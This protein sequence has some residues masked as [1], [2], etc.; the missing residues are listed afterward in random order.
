[1]AMGILDWIGKSWNSWWTGWLVLVIIG[2]LFFGVNSNIEFKKKYFRAWIILGGIAF[3]IFALGIGFPV[4]LVLFLVL[5]MAAFVTFINLKI[6]RICGNCGRYNQKLSSEKL[7]CKD[8]G[9]E[10]VD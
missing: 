1:M 2:L 4:A 9:V 5:P 7:Y 3:V 8:C 10:I 6:A